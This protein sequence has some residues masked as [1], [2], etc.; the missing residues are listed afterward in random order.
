MAMPTSGLTVPAFQDEW[1][2]LQFMSLSATAGEQRRHP[3]KGYNLE[4]P[5]QG[6]ALAWPVSCFGATV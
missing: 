2:P 6:E 1:N 3:F 5:V 4:K